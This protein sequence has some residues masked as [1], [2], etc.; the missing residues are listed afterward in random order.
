MDRG[1]ACG[2]SKAVGI[3]RI[4]ELLIEVT[5]SPKIQEYVSLKGRVF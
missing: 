3:L 2:P 5:E 1:K 4:L